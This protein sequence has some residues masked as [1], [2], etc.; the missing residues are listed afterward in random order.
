MT[1]SRWS[2]EEV[3]DAVRRLPPESQRE[4]LARLLS[5]LAL[6]SEDLPWLRLAESAFEFWD[7][8][9]DATYDAL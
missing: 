8:P 7:N 2:V 6:S 5:A 9:E 1:A 4:V 3:I